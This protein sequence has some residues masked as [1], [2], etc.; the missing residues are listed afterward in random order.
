MHQLLSNGSLKSSDRCNGCVQLPSCWNLGPL[1]RTRAHAHPS[2]AWSL[3]PAAMVTVH[4]V[5]YTGCGTPV[6]SFL[7]AFSFKQ[8]QNCEGDK[9]VRHSKV[10]GR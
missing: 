9:D 8:L 5:Q 6:L 4:D 7:V 10:G 2:G 1:I 3:G